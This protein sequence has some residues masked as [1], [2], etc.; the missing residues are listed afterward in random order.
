MAIRPYRAHDDSQ[1]TTIV[2]SHP[3]T[4]WGWHTSCFTTIQFRHLRGDLA[5]RFTMGNFK[6][7]AMTF[8][9]K[10][11]NDWTM[12]LAGMLAYNLLMTIFPILLAIISIAGLLLGNFGMQDAVVRNVSTAL[13]SNIS[14]IINLPEIVK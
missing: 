1:T 14:S 8:F 13:P 12:N 6:D 11:G 4:M 7:E 10:F 5:R 2:T 9:K 3:K